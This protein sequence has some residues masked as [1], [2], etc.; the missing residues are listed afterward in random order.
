MASLDE[1]TELEQI[2]TRKI[3]EYQDEEKFCL[4]RTF[5]RLEVSQEDMDLLE[6]LDSLLIRSSNERSNNFYTIWWILKYDSK[7]WAFSNT[8]GSKPTSANFSEITKENI[9]II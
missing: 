8:Y 5:R 1:L 2:F 3:K 4:N 9:L 6:T 7:L